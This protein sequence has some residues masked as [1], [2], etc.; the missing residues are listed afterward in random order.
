MGVHRIGVH[1]EGMHVE[2]MH[3]QG[4]NIG[5]CTGINYYQL[6]EN[7]LITLLNHSSI[8]LLTF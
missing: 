5:A 8:M 6:T 1:S 3:D 4:M 2:G 7:I